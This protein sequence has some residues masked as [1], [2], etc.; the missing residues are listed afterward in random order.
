MLRRA[1]AVLAASLTAFTLVGGLPVVPAHGAVPTVRFASAI[2]RATEGDGAAIVVLERSSAVGRASVTFWTKPGTAVADA[3]YRSVKRTVVFEPGQRVR[4]VRVRIVQDEAF[5]QRETVLLRLG[6]PLDGVRPGSRTSATLKIR[7]DEP[8][9]RVVREGVL[10]QDATWRGNVLLATWVDVPRGITLTIE[11]GTMVL[12]EAHRDYR[13]PVKTTGLSVSGG[14]LLANGTAEEQIWFTSAEGE[15]LNGDWEGISLTDTADSRISYTVIEFAEFGVAQFDSAVSVT[16]SIVRWVNWEGLY[17][18]RSRPI[19]D[20]NL[21]YANGYH[22]IA[23]EQYNT[24]VQI[25]NNVFAGGHFGAHFEETTALVEGNVF[26]GYPGPVI[27]VGMESQVTVRHNRFEGLDEASAIQIGEGTTVIL[28]DNDFGD[29]HIAPPV[30]DFPDPTRYVLDYVPGDPED[31][32]AYVFAPKDRTRR[33]VQRLGENQSFG[34]TLVYA[35]GYLWRFLAGDIELLRIDPNT[36]ETVSFGRVDGL[37]NPRGLT[38]DG[39][40]FWVNDFSALKVFQIEVTGTDAMVIGSFDIPDKSLGGTM[41]LTWDGTYLYLR[42][43]DGSK[44]YRLTRD[45]VVVGE[46]VLEAPIAQSVVW[47]GSHFWTFDGCA[48]GVC[49]FTATGQLVGEIYPVAEGTWA[50]AWD[51]EHLWSVQRT[52][53]LWPDAKIFEIEIRD[54]AL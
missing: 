30:L 29:G 44:L 4:R 10:T 41:G 43:R 24:D 34:W 46:I 15:P 23:L 5:E 28:E 19:F 36:G 1:P 51:G 39:T 47:T 6:S 26:E 38:W 22:E 32:Y 33:V 17:A 18:E 40:H 25:T 35:S 37:I 8:V 14:T 12:F 48:K 20:H 9:T 13:D 21:L 49:K 52:C 2:V 27:T 54:D 45:G 16:H 7:D 3:D 11:P 50:L 42:S 31:R 53:E